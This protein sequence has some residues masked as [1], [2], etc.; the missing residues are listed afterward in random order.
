MT[1]IPDAGLD[2]VANL[3]A[4]DFT[5]MATGSSSTAE[6]TTDT[7]LGSENTLNGSARDVAGTITAPATE[8][9]GVTKW[10]H[11]FNFTGAVTIREIAIFNAS[12]D[13]LIRNV[14]TADKNY[15]D[16]ESVTITVTHTQQ[17]V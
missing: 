1:T 8:A 6:A 15:V 5:Y 10:V 14:L 16:G 7:A 12:D 3:I 17:R 2:R 13:M 9:T 4:S 11:T